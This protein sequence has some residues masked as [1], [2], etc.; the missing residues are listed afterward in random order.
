MVIYYFESVP[1]FVVQVIWSIPLNLVFLES[2][3]RSFFYK[4]YYIY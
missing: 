4:G 1:S 2:V 3:N